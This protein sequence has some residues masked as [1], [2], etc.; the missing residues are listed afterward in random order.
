MNLAGKKAQLEH[1]VLIICHFYSSE[2][3]FNSCIILCIPSNTQ[4]M[5]YICNIFAF[6]LSF[7]SEVVQVVKASLLF[8]VV[9]P[10]NWLHG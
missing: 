4:N 2:A 5:Y 8:I 6:Y 10:E 1:P 7:L 9:A 3:Y